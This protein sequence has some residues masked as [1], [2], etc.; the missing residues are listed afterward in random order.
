MS[1]SADYCALFQSGIK[2]DV[3]FLCYCYN[4]IGPGSSVAIP[5]ELPGWTVRDRI[6]VGTIFSA[7]PDRPWGPPSLLS[8]ISRG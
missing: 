5:T 8:G 1:L 7:R 3:I 6:P 4:T 2:K